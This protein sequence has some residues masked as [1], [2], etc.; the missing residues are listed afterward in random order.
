MGFL[1]LNSLETVYFRLFL[2]LGVLLFF[3]MNY[4]SKMTK[5]GMGYVPQSV[6]HV[7][8][9]FKCGTKCGTY[10]GCPK[11]PLKYGQMWYGRCTTKCGTCGTYI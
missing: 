7:V 3:I 6:V 10:W 11:Y 5:Y 8:H 4:F 2:Q 9:I 1:G